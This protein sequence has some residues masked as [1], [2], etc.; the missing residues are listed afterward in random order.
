MFRCPSCRN[1]TDALFTLRV[2]DTQNLTAV[3]GKKNNPL[4]A[5][6]GAVVNLFNP[7]WIA[8]S[9]GG[10]F[11]RHA[12][13][14][15]IRGGL[16]VV[17]FKI[18]HIALRITSSLVGCQGHGLQRF[19]PQSTGDVI[20]LSRV[21]EIGACGNPRLSYAKNFATRQLIHFVQL[22]ASAQNDFLSFL[23]G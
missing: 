23:S 2:N 7:E 19:F 11:K 21:L 20:I 5:I 13:L 10:L 3:H 12:M 17:P 4:L 9:I 15:K 14:A 18:Y 6:V 8:K 16:G 1:N 22:H